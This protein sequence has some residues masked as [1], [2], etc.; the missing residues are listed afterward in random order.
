MGCYNATLSSKF[1]QHDWHPEDLVSKFIVKFFDGSAICQLGVPSS[2]PISLSLPESVIS[3]CLPL[4]RKR[5]QGVT[6]QPPVL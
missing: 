5:E 1:S 2:G 3:E 6:K 4:E